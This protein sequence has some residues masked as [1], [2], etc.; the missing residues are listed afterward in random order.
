LNDGS[1]R[2]RQEKICSIYNSASLMMR[3]KQFVYFNNDVVEKEFGQ[4]TLASFGGMG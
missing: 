4:S 3:T 1:G 2:Q